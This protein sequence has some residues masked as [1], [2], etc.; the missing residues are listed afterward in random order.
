M[1]SY[2]VLQIDS[3]IESLTLCNAGSGFVFQL[4][5]T[6]E[7]IA[8]PNDLVLGYLTA[9]INEVR[10][11]FEVESASGNSVVFKKIY[12]TARGVEYDFSKC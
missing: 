6:S 1:A 4:D 3:L 5:V 9:P 7:V 2:H 8:Q 10:Y 11:I 12:E